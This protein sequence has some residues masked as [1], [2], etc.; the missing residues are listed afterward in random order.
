MYHFEFKKWVLS[1]LYDWLTFLYL[2]VSA[3]VLFIFHDWLFSLNLLE[4]ILLCIL[5]GSIGGA[6]WT[7][8]EK[9]F[10][11]RRKRENRQLQ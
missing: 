2:A 4:I 3:L 11:I 1:R 8:P 10:L 9:K 6:I 5:G 7:I